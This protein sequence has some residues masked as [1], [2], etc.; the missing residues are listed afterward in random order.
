MLQNDLPLIMLCEKGEF[1]F[2]DLNVSESSL[3][4]CQDLKSSLNY[5]D[6]NNES[7]KEQCF[8]MF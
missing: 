8:S 2:S 7:A 4:N 5:Q 6:G 1:P 3:S